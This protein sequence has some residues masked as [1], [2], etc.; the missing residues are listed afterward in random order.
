[1]IAVVPVRSGLLPAGADETIAE[2]GGRALLVG[3][4]CDEAA[5]GINVVTTE[6]RVAEAGDFAPAAWSAAL[7][8]GLSDEDVVL[9]PASPDGRDLAPRVAAAL[10]RPLFANAVLVTSDR[11]IVA[12]V[13]GLVAEEYALA[14]PAVATLQPGARGIAARDPAVPQPEPV[15][16]GLTMSEVS[17]PEVVEVTPPDPA[18]M[19]LAEAQRIVAGGAGLGGADRFRTLERV[20]VAL[21]ASYGA[22]RV[23]ADVGWVPPDRFIGTTGVAVNPRLY[24]AFAI[25]G[26]VQHV[27][28]LGD[29][30]RIISVNTDASAPMMTMA[31]VAIQTDARA[32]LDA[33]AAR[34]GVQ[35]VES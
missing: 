15:K 13:G 23:A 22:S 18:T 29:P 26:A 7:R 3:T 10:G 4:G 19:D 14:G 27:G 21:G 35:G 34:L 28:G 32:M 12:R 6:V 17:D 11:V 2:A 8:S 9:L 33:L 24:I 25:S 30:E 20:A 5:A 16:I 31:D 1:V